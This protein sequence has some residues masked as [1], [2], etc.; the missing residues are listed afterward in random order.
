MSLMKNTKS[1]CRLTHGFFRDYQELVRT[2]SIPYQWEILNDQIPEA[3]KSGAVQNIKLAAGI[4]EGEYYGTCFQ[5]SDIGKWLE[6]VSYCLETKP[7]PD[8]EALADSVISLLALAQQ[9]DGYLNSY[10]TVKEPEKRFTDLR[11]CCE[12]YC[13]GHLAE[14]AA[15]WYEATGKDNLLRI[16]CRYADLLCEV[17]GPEQGQSRGY[18][19]HPE[20][21]LALARL[22]ETTGEERYLQLAD[23]FLTVRGEE[24]YYM[25]WEWEQRGRT[26]HDI[27]NKNLKPGDDR[28]Y[29]CAGIQPRFQKKAEGHAV[30]VGY[31]LTGMAAVA[32]HT[33][34]SGL[35]AACRSI[36]ENIIN[37][38]MYITGGIGSTRH[39]ERF[40]FDYDLPNDRAYAETCAAVSMAFFT[41][42]MLSLCR[43]PDRTFADTL[44]RVLYNGTLSGMSLDGTHFFYL[45][46]LEILP[47]ACVHDKDF[48]YV[49]PIRPKW[50]QCACCPPNLI[51]LISSIHRYIYSVCED[52]LYVHLYTSS[53]LETQLSGSSVCIRQETDYPWNG[54]V[55]LKL[56]GFPDDG[57]LGLRIPGW[58]EKWELSDHHDLPVEGACLQN[59]YLVFHPRGRASFTLK[60]AMT[61]VCITAS[62]LVKANAGKAALM[63]GPVV[64]CME[65][66]DNQ[67]H[68]YDII[69]SPEG[70]FTECPSRFFCTGE[71]PP[72]SPEGKRIYENA[73]FLEADTAWLEH[74]LPGQPL[75]VPYGKTQRTPVRIRFVPYFLW[76]N[77]NGSTPQEMQVWFRVPFH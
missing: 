67:P 62:C 47:E 75:Y 33:R 34:D 13:F 21:E 60:L 64:Y 49:K 54:I 56:S 15:A 50:H 20:A 39:Q 51:R 23:F 70:G 53:C 46:P 40:T 68:L 4:A 55:R 43:K 10:F 76:G 41:R 45:N 77:R 31:L 44:E 24:P 48:K 16:A 1:I 35:E 26:W 58:C 7:D 61:P 27:R 3:E 65:E 32:S 6:A 36:Y 12:H 30:K 37:Q 11:E 5:D 2:V 66:V 71:L 59:G 52:T 73:V 8:L 19:G 9:E 17:F 38:R 22:F 42:R 63:R 25:D 72:L 69:V 18:D 74:P 28:T 29:D 14:A 57:Q